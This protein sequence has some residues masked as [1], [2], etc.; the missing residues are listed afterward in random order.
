MTT[1]TTNRPTTIQTDLWR[2][3]HRFCTD[4]PD[5]IDDLDEARFVL[6]QHTGHGP[7]CPRYLTALTRASAVIG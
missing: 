5:P 1:P 4:I 6:D 7:G 2:D 3:R